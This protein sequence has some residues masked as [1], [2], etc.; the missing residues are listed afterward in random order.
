[1]NIFPST[2]ATEMSKKKE[3]GKPTTVRQFKTKTMG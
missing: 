1:M 2:L 3:S